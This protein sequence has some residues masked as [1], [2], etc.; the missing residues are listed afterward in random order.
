MKAA[1]YEKYGPPEVLR[2]T[3]LAKPEPGPGQVL[4]KVRA[5]TVTSAD[6]RLR[7]ADPFMV[8]FFAGLFRPKKPI[9]GMEFAGEIEALGPGTKGFRPGEPVFGF[10]G[11]GFGAYAEYICLDGDGLLA[12][13]P[14]NLSFEQAAALF[15]GG[16]AALHFLRKGNIG[17]GKKVLV[18]GA[19]GGVGTYAVQL[20][21][22]FGAKVTGVCGPASQEMVRSLGADRVIDYTREDFTKE[23]EAYDIVFDTVGKSPFQGSVRSLRENGV[24]LR[25]VHMSPGPILRG[26]WTNLTTSKKVVGGVAAENREDLLLLK[27]LAEEGEIRPVM[28]RVFSLEEIAE[29][30]RYVEKGHKKGNVG[31]TVGS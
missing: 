4:V 3:D 2:L 26:M 6:C 29:A 19:S 28:D 25:T 24:Y 13:K 8:R 27:Q 23:G 9:L 31:I 16:H 15:F 11:D 14:E 20:A 1:V 30:H 12:P 17:T 21:K 18:H 5:A 22:H 7:R 10:A